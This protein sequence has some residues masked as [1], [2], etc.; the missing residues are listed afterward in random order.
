M[1]FKPVISG[2]VNVTGSGGGGNYDP[3]N[4]AITGGAITG[5]PISGSTG[6]FTTLEVVPNGLRVTAEPRL[7]FGSGSPFTVDYFGDISGT[8]L[9]L[10]GANAVLTGPASNT[11]ALQNGTNGQT[12]LVSRSYIDGSNYSRLKL[13]VTGSTVAFLSDEAGTGVGSLTGYSFDR[14]IIFAT[15][16]TCDIG[17]SGANRPRNIFLSGN[18]NVESGTL[19]VSG[20]GV[21][22]VGGARIYGIDDGVIKLSNNGNSGFNCLQFGGTTS[23]F[24]ALKRTGSDLTARLADDTADTGIGMSSILIGGVRYYP[25]DTAGVLSFTTTP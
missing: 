19:S 3:S 1:S 7:I 20:N 25:H 5:T 6:S 14:S 8:S 17:S 11:L 15:D 24:P 12:F 9:Y 18:L 13:D 16:N 22:L 10:G 21:Y 4:V 23:S 2:F